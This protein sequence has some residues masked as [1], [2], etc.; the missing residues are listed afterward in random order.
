MA[1]EIL[2]QGEVVALVENLK[3]LKTQVLICLYLDPLRFLIL[4]LEEQP[5]RDKA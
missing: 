5:R 1:R 3:T 4:E 2:I